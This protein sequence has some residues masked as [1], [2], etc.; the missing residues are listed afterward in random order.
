MQNLCALN[1]A[2][3]IMSYKSIFSYDKEDIVSVKDL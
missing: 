1:E 2:S 3:L